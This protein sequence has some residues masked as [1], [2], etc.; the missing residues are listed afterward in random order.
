[1]F[2]VQLFLEAPNR[3]RVRCCTNNGSMLGFKICIA[4]S[5]SRRTRSG[6]DE[7]ALLSLPDEMKQSHRNAPCGRLRPCCGERGLSRPP[8]RVFAGCCG[9]SGGDAWKSR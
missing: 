5:S 4:V 1:M 8:R 6:R 3:A 7:L 9:A 2:L